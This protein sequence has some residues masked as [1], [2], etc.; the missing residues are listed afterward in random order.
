MSYCRWST[1]DFQC[2]LYV[3]AD[4][5]GGWSIHVA[6]TR[7]VYKEPLPPALPL[8]PENVMALYDRH[9]RVS[10]LL[11]EADHVPIGLPH[12]GWSFDG[13]RDATVAT[14]KKLRDLGY[15]F[16]LKIIDEIAA[17]EENEGEP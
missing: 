3:Y 1:D 9:R 10:E 2:D 16:P 5:D 17:G 8:T 14:L 7:P 4:V 11:K 6:K 12:D 15:R 13:C